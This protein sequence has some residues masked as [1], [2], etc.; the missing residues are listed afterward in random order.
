ML[1]EPL[2][3]VTNWGF[4]RQPEDQVSTRVLEGHH[5]EK[6]TEQKVGGSWD[7]TCD[8]GISIVQRKHCE[9]VDTN[10]KVRTRWQL[11]LTATDSDLR[12]L[13]APQFTSAPNPTIFYFLAKFSLDP[14][15]EED[16][17]KDSS[18]LAKLTY[19]K[20]TAAYFPYWNPIRFKLCAIVIKSWV[21]WFL[22]HVPTLTG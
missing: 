16:C 4:A 3:Q 1:S 7:Y 12:L 13:M 9:D 20:I 8:P 19:Y 17:G 14:Y 18:S 22:K 5:K 2:D 6:V 11:S 21:C 10:K 15:G